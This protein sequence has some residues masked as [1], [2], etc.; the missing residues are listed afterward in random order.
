MPSA[1]E[2][3]ALIGFAFVAA[4]SPGPNNIMVM[5][6][7]ANFGIR[8]TLP[9]MFGIGIGFAVMIV[10]VGLGLMALF[11]R[12]PL[13]N[14]ILT[15]ASVTYLLWLAWKIANAAPPQA[16]GDVGKPFSFL[17]ASAFQ[18]VNPKAWAMGTTAIT[19]YAPEHTL[20][21]V[22]IV[23]T[24]FVAV[25]L[26]SLTFWVFAG[27]MVQRWLSKPARLRAFNIVMALLL[28]GSLYLGLR[29]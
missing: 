26:P 11:E 29:H 27:T 13:L 21:A 24:A 18:W 9:H 1:A 14:T 20:S 2:F 28:V 23:A 25:T 3:P 10:L 6:S 7:G 19:L 5:S 15:V 16:G 12:Y 22:L 17:Q 4:A 8:R